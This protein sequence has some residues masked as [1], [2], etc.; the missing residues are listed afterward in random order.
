V[1]ALWFGPE[2]METLRYLA[3]RLQARLTPD[4]VVLL[5]RIVIINEDNPYLE[6]VSRAIQVEH[7][8]VEVRDSTF[9]GQQI[10]H[11]Y[12]ITSNGAEGV[13]TAAG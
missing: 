3:G 10:E 9:F 5:S 8:L 1:A 12:I 6:N 2:K 7:A 11:G 4:E 13:L